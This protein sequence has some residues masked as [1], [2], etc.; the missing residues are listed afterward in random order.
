VYV[1]NQEGT[2]LAVL[3]ENVIESITQ[4][5]TKLN[6]FNKTV[7]IEVPTKTSELTN[8]SDFV[9]DPDYVGT[10]NNYTDADKGKLAS[11]AANAEI[12]LIEEV[13][14]NGASLPISEK[15]VN[16]KLSAYEEIANKINE[17]NDTANSTQY[18]SAK[19]VFDYVQNQLNQTILAFDIA[20]RVS[21]QTFQLD[22]PTLGSNRRE[23]NGSLI[24]VY[25][26]NTTQ[27][28]SAGE[29][30]EITVNGVVFE[31]RKEFFDIP[32]SPFA[33]G[34]RPLISELLERRALVLIDEI[35][36]TDN[37]ESHARVF[38]LD[39]AD[40]ESIIRNEQGLWEVS[41]KWLDSQSILPEKRMDIL[42]D[43]IISLREGRI[44][45]LNKDFSYYQSLQFEC[46][47][48]N[49]AGAIGAYT[50][51]RVS[52]HL[53][54]QLQQEHGFVSLSIFQTP[55]VF[56][57]TR[58]TFRNDNTIVRVCGIRL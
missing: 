42:W 32:V 19:A 35:A 10:D 14:V 17:I 27:D 58:F 8:D 26:E 46:R 30:T 7:A 2:G 48:K 47:S 16:I 52:Q 22:I 40:G 50:T 28:D 3:E 21:H 54:N 5:G 53:I 23:L 18:A 33:A 55:T 49:A 24:V 11:I 12:N 25:F 34:Q 36:F 4:N 56:A 29:L 51:E 9:V 57:G 43:E 6:I 41:T 13:K 20:K 38:A 37:L 44:I 15:S 31:T 45:A 39:N 1:L